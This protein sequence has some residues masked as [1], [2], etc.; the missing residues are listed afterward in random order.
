MKIRLENTRHATSCRIDIRPGRAGVRKQVIEGALVPG[1]EVRRARSV[2]C[3]CSV[4][5]NAKRPVSDRCG[6]AGDFG[7]KWNV[8][9]ER[10]TVYRVTTTVR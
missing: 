1:E 7:G 6:V 3:A 9:E 8:V 10:P 4:S 5:D 2:L